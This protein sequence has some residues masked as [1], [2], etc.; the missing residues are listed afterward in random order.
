MGKPTLKYIEDPLGRA[1]AA[2]LYEEYVQQSNLYNRGV[3]GVY[4]R[5]GQGA[6]MARMDAHGAWVIISHQWGM[7][8]DVPRRIMQN[9]LRVYRAHNSVHGH[10][11]SEEEVRLVIRLSFTRSQA[12]VH[13]HKNK[14]VTR[15]R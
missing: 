1:V 6:I 5:H 7:N 10:L 12:R 2:A 4:A 9:A 8:A 3:P 13:F 11:V 14:G 15:S